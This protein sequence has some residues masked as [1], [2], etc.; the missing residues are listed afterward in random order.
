MALRDELVLG[1]KNAGIM[2]ARGVLPMQAR[3]KVL[4]ALR[5]RTDLGKLRKADA[6]VVSFAKSGRT[7]LRVMVSNLYQQ[8]YGLPTNGLM[9]LDNFRTLNAA[10]PALFFTQGSYIE[11]GYKSTSADFPFAKKPLIFLA[12]HPADVAVSYFFHSRARINPLKLDV[13]GFPSSIADMD[14]FDFVMH[15]KIGIPGIIA[16]LNRWEAV[17]KRHPRAIM[18]S[19]E[20][21]RRDPAHEL[22]RLADF[23]GSEFTDDQ[24]AAAIEFARFENLKAKEATNFFDNRR[25]KARD[26]EDDNSFK[27]RRGK[28]QG[29]VDYFDAAQTQAIKALIAQTLSPG[30]GYEQ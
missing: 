6:A 4:R 16:Y 10:I 12:R 20:K 9:E 24:Y 5:R 11:D 28:V 17:V 2:L 21:L 7:W 27:V 29:Y 3:V 15:E 19:Y 13:K 30:F 22:R 23:L 14:I 1:A 25:L 26:N 8:K 18:L